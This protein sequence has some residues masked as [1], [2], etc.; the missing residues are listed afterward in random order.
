MFCRY[1]GLGLGDNED[2]EFDE[3]VYFF[4]LNHFLC[5]QFKQEVQKKLRK[6]NNV[7]W[8]LVKHCYNLKN[9]C[10]DD[11]GVLN[12]Y[13]TAS[14]IPFKMTYNSIFGDG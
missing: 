14:V 2:D 1:F 13:H 4:E 12:I 7:W 5:S 11:L 3:D 6:V 8:T 9:P 10:L